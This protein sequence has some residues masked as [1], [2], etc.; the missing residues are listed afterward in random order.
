MVS[1]GYTSF[2]G[3]E[4]I[5]QRILEFIL[6]HKLGDPDSRVRNQAAAALVSFVPK[7]CFNLQ[8]ERVNTG[9]S[10]SDIRESID[11]VSIS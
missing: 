6:W 11:K 9:I 7:L 2:G 3:I 8:I 4:I 10:I 5:Q 1:E